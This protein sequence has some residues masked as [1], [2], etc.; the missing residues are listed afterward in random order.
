MLIILG[1]QVEIVIDPMVLDLS[2]LD[3]YTL[4]MVV[5]VTG[6]TTIVPGLAPNLP[7]ISSCTAIWVSRPEF[8]LGLD[9]ADFADFQLPQRKGGID[10]SNDY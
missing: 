9:T 1:Q 3:H 10:P 2:V 7:S 5:T 6:L 4:G 8:G